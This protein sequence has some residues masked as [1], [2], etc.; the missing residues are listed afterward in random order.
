MALIKFG[1]GIT[2]MRGSIGGNT[3]ARNRFGAYARSRTKPVNPSS[4]RQQTVR[5]IIQQITQLWAGLTADQRSAWALYGDSVGW[6]NALGETQHLSGFNMY[7]RTNML[8]QLAGAT[9]VSDAPTTLSLPEADPDFAI[10]ADA[11]DD[12][13][14][15]T[16]DNAL[17][18][19]NEAGGYLVCSLGQPVSPTRNFFGGPYR[20]AGK[21]E[22]D[23]ATPP[24]IPATFT[25]PF[26]LGSGQKVWAFARIVRAD[27]RVSVPF[28]ANCIVGA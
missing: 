22:G 26:E 19:A 16:F 11:S 4:T 20:Y 17:D 5:A 27:G 23:A 12:D 21:V 13:F 3:F 8:L 2:E 25:S 18:W 9:L 15:V 28:R 6:V 10:A 24:S 1:G 14:S 7:C